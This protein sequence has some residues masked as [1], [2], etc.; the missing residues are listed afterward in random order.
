V[1]ALAAAGLA[2]LAS[3][4]SLRLPGRAASGVLA[5]TLAVIAVSAWPPAVS[6]DGGW[7][8]ADRAAQR[9]LATTGQSPLA[10]DGI[11]AFKNANALRFPLERRDATVLDE[12][13]R[14]GAAAGVLVCDPLFDEVVGAECGGPAEDSWLAATPGLPA[15]TLLDRF[16][17]GSRRV[18]SVYAGAP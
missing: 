15:L 4:A 5:G 13:M 17:A 12:G 18:I 9:V 7:P 3:L 2:R 8:L 16:E 6:E 10:L 14:E 11:P 1:V